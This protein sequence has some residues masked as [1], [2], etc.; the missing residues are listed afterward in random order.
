MCTI[1]I[2]GC[3]NILRRDDGIGV[4]VLEEL[5]KIP[6][7]ENVELIDAGTRGMDIFSFLE[8]AQKVIIVD[9]VKGR[10]R[11]GDIYRADIDGEA[12]DTGDLNYFCIHDFN[13][14]DA[15][16]IGR[17]ILGDKFPGKIT[18]RGI[19]I[20]NTEP[21]IG[22]SPAIKE[23]LYKVVRLIQEELAEYGYTTCIRGTC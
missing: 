19:E 18:F 10:G 3:G 23:S 16:V 8:G 13:W 14:E 12:I 21:G 2:I 22:L 15:L 1:K 17:K 11:P 20:E 6:L 7:A 4:Y 9:G 5:K